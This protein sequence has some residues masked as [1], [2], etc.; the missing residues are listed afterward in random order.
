[1]GNS[2]AEDARKI[3]YNESEAREIKGSATAE[4]VRSLKEE[5]IE[6]FTLPTRK[7]DS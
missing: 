7:L 1:M 2:F 6:C 3:H 5:G 4:E